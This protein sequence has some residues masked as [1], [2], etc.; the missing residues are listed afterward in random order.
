MGVCER[1]RQT[2]FSFQTKLEPRG[3][4]FPS[5]WKDTENSRNREE[6]NCFPYPLRMEE[7]KCL[8]A[9]HRAQAPRN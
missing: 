3:E 4:Q 6:V 9:P 7:T 2:D 8:S 1:K 5:A